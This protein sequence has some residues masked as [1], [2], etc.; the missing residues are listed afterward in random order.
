M[1]HGC[2]IL[3]MA[4]MG[5]FVENCF[6]SL[7]LSLGRLGNLGWKKGVTEGQTMRGRA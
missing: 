7:W 1:V 4:L 6:Y 3:S 2:C 5:S